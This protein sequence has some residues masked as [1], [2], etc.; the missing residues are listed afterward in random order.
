MRIFTR[1]DLDGFACSVLVTTMESVKEIMFV[2]PKDAQDGRFEATSEDILVNLPYVPGCGLWFD[3]HISEEKKLKDIKGFKGAYAV[4]PS[5]ARVV[6]NYYRSPK[7]DVYKE[8]LSD[9]DRFDSGQLTTEDVVDPKGWILL[10]YTL[11]PR[12]GLGPEF[13]KY[14]RWL[15]EYVK[16]VPLD[17]VLEHREVKKRIDK[18][19]AEQAEFTQIL[20]EHA[21]QDGNVV[22]TDLRHLNN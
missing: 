3:H 20:K 14:F 5:A 18:L 17:K 13:Q 6:Y 22:L 1:G 15:V 11:D 7:L 16:E 21:K 10:G 8:M 12:S 9:I 19:R 2:H 4:A